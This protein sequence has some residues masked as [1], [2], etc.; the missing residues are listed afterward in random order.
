ML[1]E[2][3]ECILV[4]IPVD[5]PETPGLHFYGQ[6]PLIIRDLNGKLFAVSTPV[7]RTDIEMHYHWLARDNSNEHVL[8]ISHKKFI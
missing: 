6:E 1:E 3:K 4:D 7:R 8:I 2:E 5:Y